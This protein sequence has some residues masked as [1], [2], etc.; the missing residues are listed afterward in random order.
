M[1]RSRQRQCCASSGA[2]RRPP[3]S[4]AQRACAQFGGAAAQQ[5][6]EQA[7]A[8][9]EAEGGGADVK[10]IKWADEHHPYLDD[11]ELYAHLGRADRMWQ[12]EEFV[13]EAH[14]EPEAK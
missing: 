7:A 12:D 4:C 5:Q 6:G 8:G 10:D 9:G 14:Q 11:Y 13:Q 3:Y 1:L 2:P